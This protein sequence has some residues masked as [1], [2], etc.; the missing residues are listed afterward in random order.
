MQFIGHAG[1]LLN[2]EI[3]KIVSLRLCNKICLFTT[4]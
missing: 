3:E 1:K 4:L 2:L